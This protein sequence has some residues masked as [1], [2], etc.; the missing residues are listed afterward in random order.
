M[1]LLA[2]VTMALI[3]EAVWESIKMVWQEGKLSID[4]IGALVI[5]VLIAV[6][7]GLD[8]PAIVKIPVAIPYVGMV[9]TGILISR[10]ANF[11]HDLVKKIEPQ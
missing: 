3:C 8:L 11:I 10:G 4:R 2:L 9:L 5:G 6:G 1:E 7:A